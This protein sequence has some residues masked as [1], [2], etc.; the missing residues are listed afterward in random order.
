MYDV[1]RT[2]TY[3]EDRAVVWERVQRFLQANGIT[4][5]NANP[6]TGA[7]EAERRHYQDA[8]WA[9]CERAWVSDP[10]SNSASPS[11]ASPI[12]RDLTL[13]V[14]VRE[15]AAGT[16]VQPLARFTEQQLDYRN[17]PFTQPCRSTGVLERAAELDGRHAA[18]ARRAPGLV[19]PVIEIVSCFSARAANRRQPS[20][21]RSLGHRH[22]SIAE[23]AMGVLASQ[24]WSLNRD[25]QTTFSL[26]QL[27]DPDVRESE[28]ILR[29]CVHC[30][31][32]TATC[33]TYLLLGDDST[34][35]AA[36]ST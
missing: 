17:M 7:I 23:Q 5:I 11:R 27:A 32:C 24:H 9:D 16:E 25:M 20:C 26:A 10:T 4:V 15:V 18:G 21:P 30:G 28:K 19:A 31:F 12:S 2:R 1:E 3:A 22:P 36:A 35:R 34:A 6:A 33:P 13:E 8:V 14:T 29:A